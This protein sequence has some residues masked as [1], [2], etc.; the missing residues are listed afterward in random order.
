MV[1]VGLTTERLVRAGA[2]L[3]DEAGFDQVTVSALARR[4][5]V[6][7]ASLYS[8]VKNS[9]DLK[10]GI[11]LLA[12]AELADRGADALAGRAGKDALAAL[13]NVYRDYAR[14]H[15]GR[16]A[17]A[18]L[19]LTP[20][21]AAGAGGRHAEMTRAILRGYELT[22]PD[23]THAVRLLGSVFHGY[24]S[25]ELGG[26]FSHSAPDS[27]ETWTRVIDALDALLRNWPEP[28]V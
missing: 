9:Q 21:A 26:G 7:A 23:Q 28:A 19:R 10:T 18:Q 4:F 24:V 25:L 8:H 17:A 27:D 12:L 15:P 14:E 13:A 6:K 3:A 16:Y 5:D 20:E 1:R 2:E 22:E 11:A